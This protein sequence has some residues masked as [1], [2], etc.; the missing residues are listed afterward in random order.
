MTV[1]AL[2]HEAEGRHDLAARLLG[3]A[4]AVAEALGENPEPIPVV[5]ELV[6]AARH[7]LETALGT[8]F[9]EQESVG[10]HMCS[11]TLLR[12]AADAVET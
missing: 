3:G 5:G 8:D 1:A 4:V 2:F 9:A 11:A 12:A 7:R 10:R 6:R